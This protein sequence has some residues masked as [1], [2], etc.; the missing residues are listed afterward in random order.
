MS[1]LTRYS[2]SLKSPGDHNI[3]A[4]APILPGSAIYDKALGI[5]KQAHENHTAIDC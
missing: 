5:A 2:N 3:E 4:L 1:E